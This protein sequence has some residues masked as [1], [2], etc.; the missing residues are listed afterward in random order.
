MPALGTWAP[1]LTDWRVVM[2]SCMTVLSS[3][4]LLPPAQIMVP[5]YCP[6]ITGHRSTQIAQRTYILREPQCLFPRPNWDSPTPSPTSEYA[7]PR[8]KKGVGGIHTRL[9][10][11]TVSPNSDDWRKSLALCLL[12]DRDNWMINWGPC[13]LAVIWFG[14]FPSSFTAS[15]FSLFPGLPVCRRSSLLTGR[16]EPRHTT[17]ESLVLYKSVNTLWA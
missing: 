15:K 4:S 12:C 16:G 3:L 10:V 13:F 17:T 6:I 8:N 9:C 11:G 2:I 1:V 5:L 14:S 7:P